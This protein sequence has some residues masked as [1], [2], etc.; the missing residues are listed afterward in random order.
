MKRRM[1]A[2]TAWALAILAVPSA[3]AA[4][5]P[6]TEPASTIAS[7]AAHLDRLTIAVEGNV[8]QLRVM[9]LLN[10][11]RLEGGIATCMRAAGHP[12]R[13]APYVNFYRDFTDADVGFGAGQGSVFD[14]MIDGGR[15]GMLNALAGARKQHAGAYGHAVPP[16]DRAAYATCRAKFDNREY[17][18]FDRPAA[19]NRLSG[20]PGLTDGI[21]SHPAVRAAMRPYESCM[22][23]RYNYVADVHDRTDF[24]YA[25]WYNSADAPLDGESP[26]RKWTQG[27]ARMEAAFA[28]DADCRRPAHEIAMRML[29]PRIGPWE[30]KH[31]AELAVVRRVWRQQAATAGCGAYGCPPR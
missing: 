12:Y 29:A 2:V 19:S 5:A 24:L 9:E 4:R 31:R 3:G 18:D 26:S 16:R 10:Y 8:D 6:A 22:K 11:R 14:T 30:K 13:K 1:I 23:T 28:A 21:E 7:T 25:G 17:S 27:V 15:R 20:L